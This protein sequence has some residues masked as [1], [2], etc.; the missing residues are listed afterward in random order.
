MLE[1]IEL[2][3]EGIRGVYFKEEGLRHFKNGAHVVEIALLHQNIPR[4]IVV[5]G[6]PIGFKYSG[7]PNK[8]FKCGS[9]DHLV[10]NCPKKPAPCPQGHEQATDAVGTL[11]CPTLHKTVK[12][13]E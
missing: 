12:P 2:E 8:C 1:T 5:A 11:P 10:C 13:T 9:N 7:Q 6:I 3:S 4:Q